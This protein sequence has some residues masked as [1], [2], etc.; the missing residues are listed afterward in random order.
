MGKPLRIVII[1]DSEDDAI[2]LLRALQQGGYEPASERVDTEEDL[3]AALNRG[4]WDLIL[5]DYAMPNF[6]AQAAL[7]IVKAYCLDIPFIIVSGAVGEDAAVAMMKAGAHDY[8]RKDN[9]ARL[10][11]TIDRELR[12]TQE[13]QMRRQAEEQVHQYESELRSLASELSLAEERQRR[14]LATDLHDGIGQ[15]LVLAQI[16][17]GELRKSAENTSMP[18]NIDEIRKLLDQAIHDTRALTTQLS[19]P[20]LYDLGLEAALKWLCEQVQKQHNLKFRFNADAR[21][22]TLEIDVKVVIFQSVRELLRNVVRH[23]KAK[24]FEICMESRNGRVL[25]K[26][27]DN[28]AGFDQ[29]KMGAHFYKNRSFGLFSIRER[30]KALGGELII[31]SQPGNGTRVVV[32]VPSTEP[33]ISQPALGNTRN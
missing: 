26:I 23:S 25:I 28:G 15:I 17:L 2:L 14:L 8:L 20:I 33:E 3:R 32:A 30:L 27:T 10:I 31:E 18:A 11:A 9:L 16:K 6:S 4:S 7:K 22:E 29:T 13:R 19:P 1:E 12:E 21:V 24:S 5:S